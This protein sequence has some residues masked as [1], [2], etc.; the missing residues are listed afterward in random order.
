MN[1]LPYC[2]KNIGDIFEGDSI[3]DWDTLDLFLLGFLLL[4]LLRFLFF[5]LFL[6]FR[7][8]R[9]MERTQNK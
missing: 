6:F 9:D 4:F 8:D 3:L 2:M 7:K 1:G 5:L